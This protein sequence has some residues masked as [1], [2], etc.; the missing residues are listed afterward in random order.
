M[1][2]ETEPEAVAHVVER[3]RSNIERVV[4]RA[5][6]SDQSFKM[7]MSFGVA[8][9]D[10]STLSEDALIHNADLA[11]YFAKENGRNC[12]GIHRDSSPDRLE[13]PFALSLEHSVES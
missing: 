8:R 10:E 6:E 4:L 13:I 12:I 1:L 2:P 7:T 3:A 9:N 11:L 5:P